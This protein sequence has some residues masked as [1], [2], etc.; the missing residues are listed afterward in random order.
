MGFFVGFLEIF[1]HQ[2]R[3]NL[4]SSHT[5]VAQK[6]LDA[7]QISL[8]VEHCGGEAV[9]QHVRALFLLVRHQ[10][11]VVHGDATEIAIV[12]AARALAVEEEGPL[13]PRLASE[14]EVVADGL[15]QL[16]AEGH[17]ALLVAL[18]RHLELTLLR[19]HILHIEADKLRGT[20]SGG[21][22]HQQQEPVALPV[23]V[24]RELH[25]FEEP[26]HL[27]LGDEARQRALPLGRL[28][29]PRGIFVH[30]AHAQHVAVES[31]HRTEA[32][33]HRGGFQPVVHH[34]H[35]P[36]ADDIGG[37]VFPRELTLPGRP[38]SLEL[39]QAISVGDKGPLRTVT[40]EAEIIEE[41]V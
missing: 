23:V 28:D 19:I 15:T 2:V 30:V 34:L 39:L 32:F 33:R 9:A 41:A 1:K 16:L 6:L 10:R 35:Y 17:D 26:V 5:F 7:H 31:L 3:V 21:V 25:V 8:V 14:R 22:E 40:L 18:A 37:H 13:L 20:E 11:Q 29:E 24:G 38:K 4:C 36:G 27:A 12:D